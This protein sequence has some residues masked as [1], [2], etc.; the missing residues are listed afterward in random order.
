MQNQELTRHGTGGPASGDV[1]PDVACLQD[2][3]VNLYFV[4]APQADG[5]RDGEGGDWV[6]VDAGLYGSAGRIV[7]FAEAR[8]GAGARPAAIVVTHGHFDHVGALKELAARWDVAVYAHELEMPYITGRSAYPPPDPT[9][10]GGAMARLS[11][12]YPQKPIDLEGRS[13]RPLPADG[14]VPGLPGWRWI[15]TPGHTPGHVSLFRDRDR[16]L[17]AGDAFVTTKQ[18]SAV[19]VL[20]QKQEVHGPPMYFTPDWGAARDSVISLAGLRPEVAATGHGLPMRGAEMLRQL[21]ELARDFDELAVPAH[22]RYV[23]R[24]AVA[25]ERGVVS[26]PPPVADPVSKLIVGAGAAAVAGAALLIAS[27]ARRGR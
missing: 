10:G 26:V 8:F 12:L 19:A 25:D 5:P 4:G 16:V 17:I 14:S 23:G 13:V 27:R 18:E 1:A 7:R 2:K 6:L 21:D 15:H 22:G 3:I 9:V 24:P 11:F 20:T